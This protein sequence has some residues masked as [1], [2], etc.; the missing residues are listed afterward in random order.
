V[1]PNTSE[2][3]SSTQDTRNGI[4]QIRW[5]RNENMHRQCRMMRR[6]AH[7]E[8]ANVKKYRDRR[9]ACVYGTSM[10]G[11]WKADLDLEFDG[12]YRGGCAGKLTKRITSKINNNIQTNISTQ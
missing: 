5:T 1:T 12:G 10:E 7:E 2:R 9:I 11:P 8:D 6:E 3:K 4:A